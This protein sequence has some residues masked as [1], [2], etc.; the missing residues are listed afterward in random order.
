[1]KDDGFGDYRYFVSELSVNDLGLVGTTKNF[2]RITNVII[3]F[4][5]GVA[6]ALVLAY[7]CSLFD[8]T[9]KSKEEL[10]NLV[11]ASV[12]AVISE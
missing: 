6:I 12:L 1:M 9:I 7:V 4:F 11:G 2:S 5:I 3:A 10:E 8:R